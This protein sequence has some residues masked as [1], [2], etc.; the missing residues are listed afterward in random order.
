MFTGI[1]ECM[2]TVKGLERTATGTRLAVT[3]GPMAKEVK[4][5]E[6]ISVEGACLTATELKG[7]QA[8]FDVSEE[9]LRRTTLGELKVGQ[10]VNLERSLRV[11]DRM[12]GHF[13]QGHI[14]GTA[15]IQ[16]MEERPG[17]ITAWFS[18]PEPLA[19]DMIEKGS[20]AVD[21]ISLTVVD[22]KSN[23]GGGPATFSVALIPFTLNNTTL[24]L[25]KVGDRV[26]IETD[27]LGKWV[28]RLLGINPS[29][30][31]SAQG[32]EGTLK[33]NIT[34]EY[35]KSKGFE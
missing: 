21:G 6:S 24:G 25:K 5:G 1:I 14:D 22:V 34:M 2:G 31:P 9:T 10:K 26:N 19:R 12:G 17:Q 13:V 20:V 23:A 33:G 8:S 29:L 35:L 3:L 32:N 16:K 7:E 27:V 30:P 11:G 15:V 4:S 28:K 18:V